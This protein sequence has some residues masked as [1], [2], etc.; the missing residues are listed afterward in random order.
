VICIQRIL[1]TSFN[2]LIQKFKTF[3]DVFKVAVEKLDNEGM[4][5]DAT[6]VYGGNDA[7]PLHV[8]VSFCKMTNYGMGYVEQ[9]LELDKK[10]SGVRT[11]AEMLK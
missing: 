8:R 2:Y 9:K 5:K 11:I 7:I 4:I 1:F 10:N 3:T 6:I